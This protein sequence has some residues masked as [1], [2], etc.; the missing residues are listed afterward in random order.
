MSEGKRVP[1]ID[2]IDEDEE[3]GEDRQDTTE[4]SPAKIPITSETGGLKV[5]PLGNLV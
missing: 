5:K 1:P 2:K 3:G 4:G